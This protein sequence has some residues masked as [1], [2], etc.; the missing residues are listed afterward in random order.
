MTKTPAFI[1]DITEKVQA[2]LNCTVVS[3][4]TLRRWEW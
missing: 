3:Y 2:I 1:V 4:K